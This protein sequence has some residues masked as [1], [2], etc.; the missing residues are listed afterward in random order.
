MAARARENARA[1][2]DCTL[3]LHL[4]LPWPRRP[5]LHLFDVDDQNLIHL[6]R[7]GDVG[8]G[9]LEA[10]SSSLVD[11]SRFGA[12]EFR[13]RDFLS[14]RSFFFLR[15]FGPLT[16]FSF[17]CAFGPFTLFA[18][19]SLFHTGRVPPDTVSSVAENPPDRAFPTFTLAFIF[20]FSPTSFERRLMSS[21]RVPR[22]ETFP[23]PGVWR[24]GL[25][26]RPVAESCLR[27]TRRSGC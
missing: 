18:R 12:S 26:P 8:E 10:T 6:A 9:R 22:C 24:D 2:G 25:A 16:R 14:Q 4:R 27:W 11:F 3:G 1:D 20:M 21:P 5:L 7:F 19:R 15:A 13:C 17:V 23:H